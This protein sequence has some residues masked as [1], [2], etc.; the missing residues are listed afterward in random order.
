MQIIIPMSGEGKRF[1]NAGIK[2]PKP[3]IV[4]EGKPIIHHVI[5]LFPGEKNFIFICNNDHLNNN[6][7]KFS[8]Y[9]VSCSFLMLSL[10]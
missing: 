10:K 1:L 5:D 2:T 3:L 8:P 9:P 6:N 4:V 7:L